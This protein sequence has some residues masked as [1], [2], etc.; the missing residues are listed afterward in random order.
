VSIAW[1]AVLVAIRRYDKRVYPREVGYRERGI[2]IEVFGLDKALEEVPA[3]GGCG[4][5]GKWVE[6][7]VVIF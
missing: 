1:A 5:R 3:H 7:R 6:E 4:I 2:F